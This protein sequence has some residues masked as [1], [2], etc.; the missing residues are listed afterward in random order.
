MARH[1]NLFFKRCIDIAGSF[2]G[3][4]ILSPLFLV[5]AVLIKVTSSGP[6]FFKQERLG[7]NGAIFKIIKFR[8]MIVNAE[9]IGDGVKVKEDTDSRITKLGAVLRKTS[10][11]EFPQLLNTLIGDMSLVGPRPPVT[12]HPYEGYERYPQ[13]AQKRFEMRPGI[14]GLAQVTVRNSA[15]WDDRIKIDI[16]YIENFNLI[17]DL[18]VLF[19]TIQRVLKSRDIYNEK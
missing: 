4:V 5:I 19:L 11:D 7:R 13:W 9:N 3:L 17:L 12:Y 14:T 16:H 8:T 10:L 18:K 1:V 15:I 6:I 2:I